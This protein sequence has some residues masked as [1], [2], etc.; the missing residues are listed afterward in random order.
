[1]EMPPMLCVS[2]AAEMSCIAA[3]NNMPS[4]PSAFAFNRHARQ[5]H[6]FASVQESLALPMLGHEW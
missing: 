4:K 1:M 2:G 3:F 5:V 6:L